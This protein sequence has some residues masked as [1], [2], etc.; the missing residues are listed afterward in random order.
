M[1][2]LQEFFFA[3]G[4]VRIKYMRQ[5]EITDGIIVSRT[6]Y[7]PIK[8]YAEGIQNIAEMMVNLIGEAEEDLYETDEDDE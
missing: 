2:Q 4:A 3:E 6:I 8:D 5:D 7:I 1:Y